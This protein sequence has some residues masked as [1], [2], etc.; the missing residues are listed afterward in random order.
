MAPGRY[1][2]RR[3]LYDDSIIIISTNST[4]DATETTN[5]Q[6]SCCGQSI[7]NS[8][9]IGKIYHM[10]QIEEPKRSQPQALNKSQHWKRKNRP[11]F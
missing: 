1:E 6:C 7:N 11:K 5:G 8:N 4:G 2:Q 9:A 10:T 3:K